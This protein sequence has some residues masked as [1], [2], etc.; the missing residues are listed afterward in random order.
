MFSLTSGFSFV[1]LR[2]D[3]SALWFSIQRDAKKSAYA[4]AKILKPRVSWRHYRIY[5]EFP[6]SSRPSQAK[7]G[8]ES[9]NRA[10][11]S[12]HSKRKH[13]RIPMTDESSFYKK[14]TAQTCV[15][16]FL[17]I[18]AEDT[19]N[20][21]AREHVNKVRINPTRNTITDDV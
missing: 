11:P 3:I 5:K 10:A 16:N 14:R 17:H 8:T 15:V 4:G 6:A 19:L 20:S 9:F 12:H 21:L 18:V 7:M 1:F 2:T 13:R